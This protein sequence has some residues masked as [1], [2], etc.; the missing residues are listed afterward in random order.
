MVSW[1]GSIHVV[2]GVEA[3]LAAETLRDHS[4]KII[5]LRPQAFAV[6]RY[7]VENA[8][9]LV[10]KDELMQA[11]WP[12]IAVTDDSLVQCIHDIRRALGDDGRSVLTTVPRRGYHLV[13]PPRTVVRPVAKLGRAA[14]LAGAL[15]VVF[16]LAVG[17]GLWFTA[18][19]PPDGK[20]S[21]A[22]LPFA[23]LS[24][25]PEQE[26]FADGLADD[27]IT[28]LSKI[29]G[30]FVVSRNSTSTYKGKTA[31][32]R[33]VAADLSVRYVL[34]G[35]VRRV[36]DEVRINVQLADATTGGYLWT[37]RYDG[38]P[39]DVLS[40]P[41]RV[42]TQ[43]AGALAL[44]LTAEQ[45]QGL[46]RLGT[47]NMEAHDAYLLGLSYYFRR[48]P[49]GFAAARDQFRRAIEL[50]P[51]Y[52]APRVAI[53]KIYAQVRSIAYTRALEIN[54]FEA[55]AKARAEL[56]LIDAYDSADGH[57]VLSWLALNRH[58]H[59]RAIAEAGRAL[60]LDPNNV[61]AIESLARAKIYS[62]DVKAGMELAEAAMRQNPA[63]LMHPLLLMGL[64]EFASDNPSRAVSYIERAFDL[65]SEEVSYAGI[66]AAAYGLMGRVADARAAFASFSEGFIEVPDLSRSVEMFPFLNSE[67][68]A[69]LAKGLDAAGAKVWFAREDGG[70]LSLRRADQLSG[71]EIKALLAEGKIE[72]K[73]FW[74]G[75]PWQRLG[76][77]EGKVEYSGRI[78]RPGAS[79]TVASRV[80]DDVICEQ[81]LDAPG[82]QELCSTIFRVPEGNA[83]RRW[84][85]YVLVTD[86]GPHPFTIA[87]R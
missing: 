59:R 33:R 87:R 82:S 66:L 72:G 11:I 17:G 27:L 62:G 18:D 2:N 61:D 74:C 25:D 37:E 45:W 10:G 6:L 47:E 84:G 79:E 49:E 56:A 26:Y 40:L 1:P 68:L 4:G 67:V 29:S 32:L 60:E 8:N 77:A 12:G 5:A 48:T 31:S 52:A 85:N 22:V 43:V 70:Y 14:R 24:N 39:A 54:F 23:N 20:P 35:S 7:L 73:D 58:Q 44:D 86:T 30:L 78:I 21:I 64:A 57:V 15:A 69:R 71:Q 41:E 50:D 51:D 28:D 3:D 42:A 65:G 34:E 38:G 55:G 19:E 36:G 81:P 75:A 46:G 53:A 13:L 63:V 80:E 76:R 9:R 83:Q 16:L